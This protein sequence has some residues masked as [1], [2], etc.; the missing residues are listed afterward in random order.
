MNS[1]KSVFDSRTEG[2]IRTT[3]KFEV[4]RAYLF[5]LLSKITI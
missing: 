5:L 2:S 4:I 1:S 3:S